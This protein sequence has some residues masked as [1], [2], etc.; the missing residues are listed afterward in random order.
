MNF[1]LIAAV[2]GLGQT[3]I[4]RLVSGCKT[5]MHIWKN[6]I[7]DAI[8][9]NKINWNRSKANICNEHFLK[10]KKTWCALV[11]TLCHFSRQMGR[12]E[13]V[14]WKP[15]VWS[16]RTTASCYC[17]FVSGNCLETEPPS[18]NSSPRS[19]WPSPCGTTRAGSRW[20][21][22]LRCPKFQCWGST[23]DPN[24]KYKRS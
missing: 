22:S 6:Y 2:I 11:L 21:W 1:Y 3:E 16:T 7:S 5:T 9:R 19:S 12:K 4:L 8:N 14:V 15:A 13:S 23:F 20:R 17:S 18:P 10:L 24:L